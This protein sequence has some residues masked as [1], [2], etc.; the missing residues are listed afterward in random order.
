MLGDFTKFQA[1]YL[2]IFTV[3]LIIIFIF[4]GI[5]ASQLK[6]DPSFSSLVS[7]KSEFNKNDRILKASFEAN[8][9]LL[10]L[11]KLDKTTAATNAVRTLDDPRIEPYINELKETLSQSQYVISISELEIDES[12]TVGRIFL[13]MQTPNTNEGY[14]QVQEQ[15]NGLL[16]EVGEP[17]GVDTVLTGLPVLLNRITTLLILD[18]LK[19]IFITLA[20]IFIILYLYS[21]DTVFTLC[22]IA[23]PALSLVALAAIM[24]IL[25]ISV[26]ITLAAV[27]VLV[28]GLGA[29][30]SIHIFIHYRAAR[31]KANSKEA[32]LVETIN[33]LQKPILASFITTLAGFVALMMG[34]SP[35]SIAQ[36]IVL[37]LAITI[38]FINTFL[39]FP[40]LILLF[41]DYMHLKENTLFRKIRS[42]LSKF[43][44]YQAHHPLRVLLVAALLTIVMLYGASQVNF[45]TSNSNWIPDSDP[46]SVSFRESTYAFGD[47]DTLTVILIA[48]Q[49]DL[50]E[51]QLARDVTQLKNQLEQIPNVDVVLTPFDDIPLNQ[52]ELWNTLTYEKKEQFSD[53]F[54]LTRIQIVS[55]NLGVNDDGSSQTLFEVRQILSNMDFYNAKASLHGDPVRFEELGDS[56]QKD[57]GI[58]TALGLL[59][60]FLVATFIYASFRI[61]FLALF[62]I[63]IAV[64][65]TVGLMGF[66]NVPFTSLSTGII[67]LVLGVGVDFSIHL[68]DGINSRFK[69]GDEIDDAISQTLVS[70]GSAILLS[71]ITT[72]C[73]FL[74]LTF[75]TL[76]GTQRLGWSLAFSILAVFLVTISIVPAVMSFG[77][78]QKRKQS[79]IT[80][81][82]DEEFE[83][84]DE[85][86]PESKQNVQRKNSLKNTKN[87]ND[88][89]K[90]KK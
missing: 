17:V 47:S 50:R 42:F 10:L 87:V 44:I 15:I 67:S 41:D 28:L 48:K 34:V 58:T 26:T 64:I 11:I 16:R 79:K 24:V 22:L 73:G 63:I 65:W 30:Y 60:V 12:R 66:F 56:L 84:N 51:V 9:G 81:Q 70:S 90:L 83:S 5:L 3:G 57:A 77:H 43:A 69:K 32:A 71:S 29:D 85:T 40:V 31:R 68:V 21:K 35:S 36:G 54:T 88:T 13:S 2:P 4:F 23:P 52:A 39:L 76:L 33:H 82:I 55:Q 46:I 75:A 37:A 1:K 62:P 20:T 6:I 86:K 7:D 78:K 45:S 27:G 89:N 61:G 49:G 19:T 74:A 25:N 14:V 53:D 80:N 72:I 18:N 59:L 38:I 8:D